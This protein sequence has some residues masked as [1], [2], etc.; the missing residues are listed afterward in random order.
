[1][2]CSAKRRRES[3]GWHAGKAPAGLPPQA[4]PQGGRALGAVYG[5]AH[6][7]A[8]DVVPLAPHHGPLDQRV[9]GGFQLFPAGSPGGGQE[10]LHLRLPHLVHQP[11]GTEQVRFLP[12]GPAAAHAG[13][14]LPRAAHALKQQVPF[15]V[16]AGFLLCHGA[17]LQLPGHKGLIPGEAADA[18]PHLVQAGIPHVQGKV[19]ALP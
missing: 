18:L 19:R 2:R 16:A 7:H 9:K 17:P 5:G 6:R 4:L 3:P 10:R 13:G 15:G 1:M 11:V 14:K 12:L 8:G